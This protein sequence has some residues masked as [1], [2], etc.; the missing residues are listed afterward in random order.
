V[1]FIILYSYN[2]ATDSAP[3]ARPPRSV[4][5]VSRR[6]RRQTPH[7]QDHQPQGPHTRSDYHEGHFDGVHPKIRRFDNAHVEGRLTKTTAF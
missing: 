4:D 3:D 6:P 5:L 1:N 2:S 7:E